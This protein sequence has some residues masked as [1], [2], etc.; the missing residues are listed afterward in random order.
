MSP[1]KPAPKGYPIKVV[2]DRTA[3]IVNPSGEPG[4]LFYGPLPA[5]D[6]RRQWL[7]RKLGE[8][9]LEYIQDPGVD[10]LVQVLQ[11]VQAL[12]GEHDLTFAELEQL[13]VRDIRG[14][15][16]DCVMMYG[17]HPEYDR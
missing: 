16:Q 7:A 9:T 10:E 2:R 5:G 3:A 15:F 6:S 4:D 8:E 14:G 17:R 12:A 1:L 13:A 11:A